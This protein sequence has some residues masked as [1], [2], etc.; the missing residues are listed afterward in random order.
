MTQ[1]QS[2]DPLDYPKAAI[3]D[4]R[5]SSYRFVIAAMLM[6]FNFGFGLSFFVV[7]PVTPLIIDDYGINRSMASMLIGLVVMLQAGFAIP[8]GMLIGRVGLKK[9][10]T[11]ALLMG[12]LPS[13]SFLAF[14]FPVLLA[15]RVVYGLGFAVIVPAIGPLQ[16]QWFRPKELPL[17]N[18]MGLAVAS[19]GI[20]LST[21][22]AAPLSE[23]IGWKAVLSLSGTVALVGAV[24]WVVLGRV[25]S[26]VQSIGSGLSIRGVWRILRDRSTL[27]MAMADA[28]PFAQYV[29][30][31]T[32]LP[33]FYHEVYG[34]SLTKAGSIV[35]L[36]SLTGVFTVLVAG[37][38]GMRVRRRRPFL[39]APGIIVGFAGLGSF[40][41]AD[42]FGL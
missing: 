25:E 31:T 41:L 30:L 24:F 4:Q 39:I 18:G 13:L 1:S 5:F 29:A 8:A 20:S 12:A 36:L 6:L 26:P 38:V 16:M 3:G 19:L 15:L 17:I 28:G 22:I 42:S 34:M 40:L 9:L 7:A 23:A 10:I 21:F 32:W 14:S 27:L 2:Q 11:I 35:G 37:I 33:S